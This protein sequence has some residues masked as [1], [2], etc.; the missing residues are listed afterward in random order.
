MRRIKYIGLFILLFFIIFSVSYQN[1]FISERDNNENISVEISIPGE[2]HNLK[3]I[4]AT[5]HYINVTLDWNSPIISII[6]YNE[7]A[8]EKT[9]ISYYEWIY[10]N[11]N[12]LSKTNYELSYIDTL[13]CNYIE[14][15]NLYSFYVGVHQNAAPG[16]WLLNI[17]TPTEKKIYD[18][19]IETRSVG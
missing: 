18:V 19:T 15:K 17:S 9:E 13:K 6:L 2:K 4:T 3:I 1:N 5:W 8:T 16:V 12:W 7:T 14:R 11:G 10:D